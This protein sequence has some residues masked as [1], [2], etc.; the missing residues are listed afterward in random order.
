MC[1]PHALPP[2]TLIRVCPRTPLLSLRGQASTL[3]LHPRL[4]RPHG[5]ILHSQGG[6]GPSWLLCSI[7]CGICRVGGTGRVSGVRSPQE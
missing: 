5:G 3:Q 4:S 2:C 6:E 1:M 7:R